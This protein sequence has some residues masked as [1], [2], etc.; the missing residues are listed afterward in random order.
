MYN[1]CMYVT[2]TW[3]KIISELTGNTENNLIE[4]KILE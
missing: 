3:Y 1:I 4:T 2:I